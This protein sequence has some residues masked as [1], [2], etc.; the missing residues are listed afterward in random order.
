MRHYPIIAAKAP[1][2]RPMI[3][4]STHTPLLILAL[5]VAVS[6]KSFSSDVNLIIP[7]A[8]GL[9]IFPIANI[10]CSAS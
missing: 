3:P 9:R 6:W 10:Y 7:K 2:R 1:V 5:S 8:I 4:F